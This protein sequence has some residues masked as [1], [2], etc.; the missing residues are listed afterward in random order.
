MLRS[1]GKLAT[2]DDDEAALE[3][4]FSKKK[5][6]D[7]KQWLASFVPGTFLD[8]SVDQIS[9]SDF[10]NKAR[11]RPLHAPQITRQLAM[12]PAQG[13]PCNAAENVGLKLLGLGPEANCNG[14]MKGLGYGLPLPPN[15]EA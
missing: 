13:K 9:Y 11:A 12:S 4:A 10:V 15:P 5:A 8:Q 2:G 7:R 3:L 6:D 1:G 14:M